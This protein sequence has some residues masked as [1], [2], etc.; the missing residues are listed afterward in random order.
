MSIEVENNDRF[1]IPPLPTKLPARNN[2]RLQKTAAFLFWLWGWK[3]D[4]NL[5]HD[6]SR[7]V[8]IGVP[9]TSNWDFVIAMI[10]IFAIDI[11]LTLMGKH[12]LFVWPFRRL[13]HWMGVIPAN[14]N[15]ANGMVGEAIRQF[16]QRQQFVLGIAPEGT[17]SKVK[18][19]RT[20]FYHIAQGADV[21]IVPVGL[22]FGNKRIKFG[23]AVWTTGNMEADMARIKAFYADVV[24]KRPNLG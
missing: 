14:R 15:A 19:W 13:L 3:F 22:D 24:G 9:H 23:E 11:Q 1:G 12:T 8:V 10:A 4:G 6:V 20:G 18:K 2:P 21:P 5:P 17:R 16:E 7:V